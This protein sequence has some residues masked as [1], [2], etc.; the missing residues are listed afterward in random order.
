MRGRQG[1]VGPALAVRAQHTADDDQ[2]EIHG[3]GAPG[4]DARKSPTAAPAEV[5]V[6]VVA[7]PPETDRG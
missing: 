6:A 2:H 3:G 7:R 1:A 5:D 4:G